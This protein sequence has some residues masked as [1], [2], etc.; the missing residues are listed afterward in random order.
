MAFEPLANDPGQA[1]QPT[2]VSTNP[3]Q[4]AT[5]VPGL[6]PV[7]TGPPVAGASPSASS[8][9]DPGIMGTAEKMA[10]TNSS[11]STGSTAG[12]GG[13]NSLSGGAAA[14]DPSSSSSLG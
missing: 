7:S 13:S 3:G 5:T 8:Q 12:A 2:P 10:G 11:T 9:E 14:A 1:A 6:N 4:S